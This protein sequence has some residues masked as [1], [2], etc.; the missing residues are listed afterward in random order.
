ME[1]NVMQERIN[2]IMQEYSQLPQL[3]DYDLSL[4][5]IGDEGDVKAVLTQGEITFE[6][7]FGFSESLEAIPYTFNYPDKITPRTCNLSLNG[8]KTASFN[9]FGHL[10]VV[11][12]DSTEI[13]KT[14]SDQRNSLA[15]ALKERLGNKFTA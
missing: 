14:N 10:V 8:L 11:R 7:T 12:K 3:A 15:I 1:E 4:E 2:E 5:E 6:K 13:F 9:E